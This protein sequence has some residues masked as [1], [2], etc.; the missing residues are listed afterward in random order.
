[1]RGLVN[2]ARFLAGVL[3]IFS[4]WIKAN[5]TLAF[6]YRLTDY[7]EIFGVYFLVPA[8]LPLTIFICVFEML[9]GFTL[10]IGARLK[11]TLWVLLLLS[12]F[13]TFLAFYSAYFNKATCGGG[14]G[15]AFPLSS[16]ESF[17]KDFIVLILVVFVF[18]CKNEISSVFG[19]RFEN[20]LLV[21][22]L[23]SA[24][25]FPIYT[26]NYLPVV[27]FRPYAIGKN[28][29]AQTTGILDELRSQYKLKDKRT[30]IEKVMDTLPDNYE[31]DYEF[32]QQITGVIKKGKE[33]KIEDFSISNFNGVD[34]SRKI[35]GN[36]DYNFLLI[37][38]DL[39]TANKKAFNKIN[40]LAMLCQREGI[41]FIALTASSKEE[42]KQFK[43]DV[44]TDIDFYIT[45]GT[46]LKTMIR[47][48]P[49]LMLLKGGTVQDKWHYHSLPSYT[50]VKQQHFKRKKQ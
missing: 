19:P 1:M 4:G 13:F 25:A 17:A 41:K 42:I 28:I 9:A 22:A 11:L 2:I 44:E 50:D 35:I 20:V 38:P 27:D 8:A 30:G 37:C 32:I 16:W 18:I 12:I 45:D 31:K 47:S 43:K 26:Y 48:N 39:K 5:D 14:F 33:A 24:I 10:L 7:F 15:E 49:G 46:I 23:I 29:T 21:I 6:S 36:P 40:D 3:F 34:Y